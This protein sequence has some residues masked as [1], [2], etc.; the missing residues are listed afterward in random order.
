[1]RS[2]YRMINSSVGRKYLTAV[3]GLAFIGFLI[4]HL[5][6]NLTLLVDLIP[7]QNGW[8]NSYAH[9]LEAFGVILYAIEIALL[10]IFLLHILAAVIV[11]F[12]NWT[13]R[14]IGYRYVA[15]AGGAS[16]KTISSR[17]MIYTGSIIFIFVVIHVWMF[18]YGAY[19][20]TVLH[21]Q[22][23][24][25]LSKL[26]IESFKNPWI[27]G[28]Y[29]LAM[30]VLGFHLWHAFWSAFQSLG[31]NHPR[32]TPII[33]ALGVILAIGVAAGFASLPIL[34]YFLAGGGA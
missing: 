12:E 6:G 29:V 1:M 19:Y 34:I 5:I 3:A 9:H 4:G 26:V 14:K 22:E 18:K 2:L 33:N 23:V 13:A 21:G 11:T 15:D 8:F 25:D 30:I 17:T 32:Y 27:T 28:A 16:R 20:Y 31:I 7:G 24:R 10:A